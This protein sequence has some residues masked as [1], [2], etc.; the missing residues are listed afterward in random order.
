MFKFLLEI[1]YRVF[2]KKVYTDD[3]SIISYMKLNHMSNISKLLP[4]YLS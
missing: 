1:L 2:Y 4:Y 3:I